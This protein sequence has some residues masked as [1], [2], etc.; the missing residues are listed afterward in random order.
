MALLEA[1]RMVL[2]E[3]LLED[4]LEDLLTAL[5]VALLVMLAVL[6]AVPLG[7]PLEA[8]PVA[9][10]EDPRAVQMVLLAVVSLLEG[11]RVVLLEALLVGPAEDPQVGKPLVEKSPTIILNS[12]SMAEVPSTITTLPNFAH[13][14]ATDH[15]TSLLMV[16]PL[17]H[18]QRLLPS[19]PDLDLA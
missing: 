15:L 11:H 6:R 13:S 5:L 9:Q 18:S 1:L 17:S 10:R 3:V 16:R 14:I 7:A 4:L 2:Q 8:L 19:S 12:F